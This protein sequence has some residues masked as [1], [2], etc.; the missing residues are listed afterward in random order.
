MSDEGCGGAFGYWHGVDVS[1]LP[2]A[3]APKL[4]TSIYFFVN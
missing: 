3:R 2:E 4:T 1:P